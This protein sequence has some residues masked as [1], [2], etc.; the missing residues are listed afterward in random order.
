MEKAL[1]DLD[2][3]TKWRQDLEE[4]LAVAERRAGEAEAELAEIARQ[5]MGEKGQR[6]KAQIK[7]RNELMQVGA[8]SSQSAH[9][10]TRPRRTAQGRPCGGTERAAAQASMTRLGRKHTAWE[11]AVGDS[12][13]QLHSERSEMDATAGRELQTVESPP[14]HPPP[15][16]GGG[17]RL[18][19]APRIN[20]YPY[21]RFTP[22]YYP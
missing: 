8:H 19:L 15:E 20:P 3:E 18:G 16:S 5:K 14:T 21:C 11:K 10:P 12:S 7:E 4:R 9:P 17:P 2:F 1:K 6:R 22:P 13:F